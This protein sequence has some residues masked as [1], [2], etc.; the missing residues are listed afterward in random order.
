MTF[1]VT[2]VHGLAIACD[3]GDVVPHINTPL[4]ISFVFSVNYKHKINHCQEKKPHYNF[5]SIIL[6]FL[7]TIPSGVWQK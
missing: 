2:L 1:L 5:L 3:H 7:T 4:C 6:T